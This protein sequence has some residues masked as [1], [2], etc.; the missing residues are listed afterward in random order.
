MSYAFHDIRN[1]VYP[2]LDDLMTHSKIR[3]DHLT[4][5]RAIFDR[6]HF[7]KIW[8]NPHKCVFLVE[9]GRLLGF[10]ISKDGIHLDPLKVQA[11]LD[12]PLLASLNQLQS[13]QGKEKF[14]R[15]FITNY[16][17]IIKGFT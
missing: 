7:Y 6:F 8:I 3:Q 1:I 12:F 17:E 15:L 2:Y 11:I 4:H 16:A 9:S 5:L 10:I 14:L 13:L